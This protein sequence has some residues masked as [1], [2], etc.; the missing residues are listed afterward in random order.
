MKR[1]TRSRPSQGLAVVA[2]FLSLLVTPLHALSHKAS[3]PSADPNVASIRSDEI[4]STQPF[5][6]YTCP[7]CRSFHQ[8]CFLGVIDLSSQ[9]RLPPILR[10]IEEGTREYKAVDPLGWQSNRAPP[11]R[12][13]DLRFQI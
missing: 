10:P 6:T 7:I 1:K 11:L 2:L 13:S 12:N 9:L 3:T 5:A 4:N 8:Q